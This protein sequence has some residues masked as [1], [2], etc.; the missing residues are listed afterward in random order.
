MTSRCE[1][2]AARYKSIMAAMRSSSAEGMG[3]SQYDSCS[4]VSRVVMAL[5]AR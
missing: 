5:V 1:G 3:L 4:I 2:V